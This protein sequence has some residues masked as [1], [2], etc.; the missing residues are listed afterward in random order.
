LTFS[1]NE[2]LV[3]SA[4]LLST[5]CAFPGTQWTPPGGLNHLFGTGIAPDLLVFIVVSMAGLTVI[6][7]HDDIGSTPFL[8]EPRRRMPYH[9]S[10]CRRHRPIL[11][12]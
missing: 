7:A 12:Q 11:A 5:W 10:S 1:D 9:N 3:G 2:N 8:M 6:V 4:K